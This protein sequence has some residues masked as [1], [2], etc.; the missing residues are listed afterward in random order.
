M[1]NKSR[2]LQVKVSDRLGLQCPLGTSNNAG[3]ASLKFIMLGQSNAIAH[4]IAGADCTQIM[5]L[6]ESVPQQNQWQSIFSSNDCRGQVTESPCIP[7]SIS[8]ALIADVFSL[9]E[10]SF[11]GARACTSSKAIC[12]PLPG[13]LCIHDVCSSVLQA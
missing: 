1:P 9:R 5:R 6:Q 2:A 4:A 13:N 7:A 11:P 8:A 12:N 3:Q 10:P